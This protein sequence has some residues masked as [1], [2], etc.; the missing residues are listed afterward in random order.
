[1]R[2]LSS[3][4]KRKRF[5]AANASL[6]KWL[7]PDP[8]EVSR[9]Q[10]QKVKNIW[11]DATSHVPYYRKLVDEGRAPSEFYSLPE[12]F[13]SVPV[14]TR[15]QIQA[16]PNLFIRDGRPPD[17]A[18]MTA[19][20]TGNPI[21]FGVNNT[22][23]EQAGADLFVGRI[24]NGLEPGDRIFLLWGHS[25]LLGTGLNGKGK[26]VVRKIK[27]RLMGYCRVD[28]YHLDPTSARGHL[29][30]LLRFAPQ[31]VIGYSSALDM[32][33]QYNREL[34]PQVKRLGIKFVVGTAENL[35]RP[36]SRAA[37]EEFFGC[38]FV[39]EYGGVEFGAVAHNLPNAS[40]NVYWWNCILE[41][42]PNA[43]T[44]APTSQPI[45]VTGLYQRYFPIIRYR[46]DDEIKGPRRLRDGQVLSF[47]E[48]CGRHNDS[49][50]LNDGSAIHSVGLFHCIH[51][52]PQVLNIQLRVEKN[53]LRL[54]L[55]AADP[56]H[57]LVT[58]IRS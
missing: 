31:V 5:A 42:L 22:E 52:E 50:K 26:H 4:I 33:V 14:L 19:G 38:P 10:L 35:P 15:D 56:D 43:G 8:E 21:H 44:A 40:Y 6:S 25:H 29:H 48:V 41:T 18:A 20:S 57:E 58:R 34:A 55:I 32:L 17:R 12:F 45:A 47:S 51:Q 54:L 53:S 1:M 11:K 16:T 27:D 24:A 13:E 2:T 7:D 28:A 49:I 30:S 37:V 23:S 46:N 3:Q 39:M 9:V 36:D